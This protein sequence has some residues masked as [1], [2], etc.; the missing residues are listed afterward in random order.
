MADKDRQMTGKRPLPA[1]YPAL[2][3]NAQ[4]PCRIVLVC[5]HAAN[6]FPMAFG[7]LGLPVADRKAH[8]AWDPGALSLALALSRHLDA[9]LVSGRVS[10]LIYD[11]NRAPDQPTAMPARS[12]LFDVP[13]N[14]AISADARA[15]RADAIYTPFHNDLHGLLVERM[16]RGQ[17]PVIVTIHS[18]TPVYFGKLRAVEFGVIHD[19]DP[20]FAIAIR[21]AASSLPLQTELNAPYSAAD[22]VTHTLRLH[23]T[24]YGLPSA[25]LEVRSDLIDTTAKADAMAAMLAPV[26]NMGLVEIQ[27]QAKAS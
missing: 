13:G 26:L 17:S 9:V 14:A 23:A 24:P 2:I 27:R 15:M 7:T 25:M 1:C 6:D 19:A 10:R 21:D 8:I 22:G 20:R 5:E 16:A 3:E 18:F 4:G 12:E 11:L